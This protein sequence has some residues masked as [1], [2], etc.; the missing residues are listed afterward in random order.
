M[1]SP[2][3]E[4][5]LETQEST[6][7]IARPCHSSKP[8]QQWLW[9]SRRRL[10]NLGTLSCLLV[11]SASNSTSNAIS[12]YQ[13]DENFYFIR[14]CETLLEQL[15]AALLTQTSN[16]TGLQQPPAKTS[17]QWLIF[18]TDKSICSAVFQGKDGLIPESP[19]Y[20]YS[21]PLHSAAHS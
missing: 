3:V 8:E 4:G 21:G 5:C 16:A 2:D 11:P 6:V 12:T 9:V 1:Y 18:G 20:L 14:R 10:F 13:C 7:R 19:K 17:G 15:T